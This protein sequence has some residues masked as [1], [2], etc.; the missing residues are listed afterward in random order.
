LS[1]RSR[2]PVNLVRDDGSCFHGSAE[3]LH[4]ASACEDG[5]T[6][7]NRARSIPRKPNERR[8][9]LNDQYSVE[10]KQQGQ[11]PQHLLYK[12]G[13]F[14]PN[15]GQPPP[16]TKQS[17]RSFLGRTARSNQSRGEGPSHAD[18]SSPEEVRQRGRF[19]PVYRSRTEGDEGAGEGDPF[20]PE[21]RDG[22]DR[23]QQK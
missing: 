11:I 10:G 7:F 17:K 1:F 5:A 4:V 15:L 21:R 18:D 16:S 23:A 14:D 6:T 20:F 13:S 8:Q 12:S 9:G 2:H 3:D 19:P 22:Q